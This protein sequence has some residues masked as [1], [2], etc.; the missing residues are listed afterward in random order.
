MQYSVLGCGQR[1]RP[2][3]SLRTARALDCEGPNPLRPAAAV[4][5]LHCA[6]LIID[7]LPC[8][9][10]DSVRRN[11]ASVH[12]QFGEA[13]AILAAFA[14]VALA[15]RVCRR[16]HLFSIEAAGYAG[17][18][19]VDRRPGAGPG[20]DGQPREADRRV[21]GRYEDRAAF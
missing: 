10:N 19:R 5:L 20:T 15:A 14:L 12:V 7:D 21:R 18:Q 11:R 4:E 2:I 17:L 6:S 9:D 13:T 3:L 16:P 1:L 8:M